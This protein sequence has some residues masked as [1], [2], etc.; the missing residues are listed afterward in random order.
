MPFM[1]YATFACAFADE[2]GIHKLFDETSLLNMVRAENKIPILKIHDSFKERYKSATVQDSFC[3]EIIELAKKGGY[4]G[5]LLNAAHFSKSAENYSAFSLNLKKKLIGSDLILLTECDAESPREFNEIADGSILS[6]TR[7]FENNV[8]PFELGEK[9]TIAD[10]ACDC[11]SIK[12]FIELPAFAMLGDGF[13]EIT[14]ANKTAR[15]SGA[16]ICLDEPTL[17]KWFDTKGG[18]CVYPSLRSIKAAL[19]L[20]SEYGYMGISFDVMRTPSVYLSMYNAMFKTVNYTAS[21]SR[22]GC[23]RE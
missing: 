12:S 19:E 23:S 6:Y 21:L 8:T 3:K 11:E 7:L 18:R 2:R 16:R 13:T 1:T 22:E 4:K 14:S 17:T 9:K 10:F 20:M 15:L 5:I